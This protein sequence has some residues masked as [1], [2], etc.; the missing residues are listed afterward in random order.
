V[1]DVNNAIEKDGNSESRGMSE[2]II[3]M[4]GIVKKF[5]GVVA[6]NGINFNAK[7][8]EIN[9]LLGENGAGKSTLMKI[10]YGIHQPDQGE[11]FLNGRKVE[12]LKPAK[13][14]KKGIGFVRQ[15]IE[16]IPDFTVT[17]NILLGYESPLSFLNF[18]KR[19]KEV[20]TLAEKY[21]LKILPDIKVKNLG[22]AGK[23]KVEILKA[24]FREVK[25][26]ILDEP[27]SSLSDIE[28]EKM[29]QMI[30]RIAGA[31]VTIIYITHKIEKALELSNRITI[32]RQGQVVGEIH[33]D[34]E[35]I[36]K[37]ELVNLMVGESI[38]LRVS[39]G[40]REV[41]NVTAVILRLE[42][43]CTRPVDQTMPLKNISF[44]L[45]DGEI[46]AIAGVSGNGQ[47]Q[48]AETIFGLRAK[49][50]GRMY[51]HGEEL[52]GHSPK[53]MIDRGIFYVP[54][55][56]DREGLFQDLSVLFNANVE[57][58][59][60]EPNASPGF[61]R[62]MGI[63]KPIFQNKR[64][65]K[66]FAEKIISQN[67]VE[68]SNVMTK[69]GNLSGG[70]AQKVL[71][72]KVLAHDP[73]LVIVHNPTRGL[74]VKSRKYIHERLLEMRRKGMAVILISDDLDEIE[75]LGDRIAVMYEGEIVDILSCEADRCDIGKR[76]AGIKE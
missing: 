43:L 70:N 65:M 54:A 9:G 22:I 18:T 72:G 52:I 55:D 19:K 15:T 76:I 46:L 11:I 6:N 56:R 71:L 28:T 33:L 53:E 45:F 17:E 34:K 60:R 51:I 32:L 24:L 42:N 59:S 35:Q 27:T 62:I 2:Y 68:P 8:G 67:A 5:H 10:L 74:D 40:S 30:K 75:E 21:G 48:L 16:L 14:L 69:A 29:F 20:E 63:N 37:E 41:D 73:K 44:D 49:S 25:I 36:S 61:L 66:D 58:H 64:K 31:G 13:A 47:K 26:L 50:S 4:Q 38:S 23:Q 3:D 39:K 12:R 57:A 7:P 1:G